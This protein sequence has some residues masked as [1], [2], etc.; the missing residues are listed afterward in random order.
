MVTFPP[1][2]FHLYGSGAGDRFEYTVDG[3]VPVSGSYPIS[4]WLW[5]SIPMKSISNRCSMKNPPGS[6]LKVAVPLML[7]SLEPTRC[8]SMFHVPRKA[9]SCLRA[10]SGSG[11]PAAITPTSLFAELLQV[12]VQPLV[13]LRGAFLHPGLEHGVASF[14][15]AAV[16]QRGERGLAIL[17]LEGHGLDR[18]LAGRALVLEGPH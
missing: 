8:P 10:G 5:I 9:S 3:N 17:L 4:S 11:M 15:R 1:S 2:I 6:H 16:R 18:D 13:R 7:L 12:L 14:L